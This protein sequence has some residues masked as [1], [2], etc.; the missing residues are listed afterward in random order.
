MKKKK[1]KCLCAV[2]YDDIAM[3]VNNYQQHADAVRMHI[4]EMAKLKVKLQKLGLKLR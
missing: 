2:K 1:Q 4:S 3:I